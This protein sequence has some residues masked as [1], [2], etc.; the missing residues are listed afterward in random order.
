MGPWIATAATFALVGTAYQCFR[1]LWAHLEAMKFLT[2]H[3]EMLREDAQAAKAEIPWW[4][5][6]KRRKRKK[7]GLRLAFA[8]LTPDEQ[9]QARNYDRSV[10]GWSFLVVASVIATVTSWIATLPT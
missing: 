4:R 10:F 6:F 5:P 8:A 9:T 3:S 1:D 7:N 2:A